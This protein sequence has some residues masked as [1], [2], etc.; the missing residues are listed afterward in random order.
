MSHFYEN[1]YTW[2]GSLGDIEGDFQDDL[3]KSRRRR[4]RREP[5][6]PRTLV[7]Q[8]KSCDGFM[9]DE[10]AYAGKIV[11]DYR[12]SNCHHCRGDVRCAAGKHWV[13]PNAHCYVCD[14]YRNDPTK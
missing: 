2:E 3:F 8:C 14:V 6:F 4:K 1:S 13:K 10:R 7:V 11:S 9:P 12:A 5:E